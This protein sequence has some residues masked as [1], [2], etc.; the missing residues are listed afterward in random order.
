MKKLPPMSRGISGRERGF[1]L[2]EL[3][4]VVAVVLILASVLIPTMGRLRTSAQSNKCLSNQRQIAMAIQMAAQ[5]LG[6]IYPPGQDES[7]ISWAFTLE[8]YLGNRQAGLLVCPARAF[9]PP[10]ANN[11]WASSYSL[12]PRIMADVA[13]EPP[14]KVYVAAVPRP[15]EVI[16]VADGGLRPNG[17]AHGRFWQ[18][19]TANQSN[20][21][22][23]KADQFINDGPDT[24][25]GTACFRFRHNGNLNV[26]FADG[27]AG[28]FPKGSIKY[29]NLHIAY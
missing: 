18:V 20:P 17:G 2:I 27:H 23:G 24:D 22:A 7:N 4:A 12:N 15:A 14:R 29:R 13:N 19:D 9:N 6:N 16:L 8:P 10:S 28:T 5:D 1:T 3:T 21:W 11:Y 25:D 26:V